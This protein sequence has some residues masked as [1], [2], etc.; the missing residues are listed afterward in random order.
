MV[1]STRLGGIND[2]GCLKRFAGLVLFLG[3]LAGCL[4]YIPPTIFEFDPSTG[5]SLMS[6]I[7]KYIKFLNQPYQNLAIQTTFHFGSPVMMLIISII[8]LVVGFTLMR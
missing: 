4:Y 6:F 1:L 8:A 7:I 5:S 3:G 2:M